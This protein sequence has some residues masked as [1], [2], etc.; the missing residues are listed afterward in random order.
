MKGGKPIPSGTVLTLVQYKAVLDDKG[1]PVEGRPA[2]RFRK[3]DLVAYTVMEKRTGWGAEYGPELR[4]GDWEYQVFGAGQV[5]V[6]I[7]QVAQPERSLLP[8]PQAARRAGLRDLPGARL[9]GSAARHR[10]GRATRPATAWRSRA[11]FLFG[12]E[13]PTSVKNQPVRD[14][15][16]HRRL[17]S[18]GDDRRRG[19]HAHGPSSSKVSQSQADYRSPHRAGHPT[20]H[21]CGLHPGMKGKVDVQPGRAPALTGSGGPRPPF[22]LPRAM[23]DSRRWKSPR[24]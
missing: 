11:D 3:G 16:Q 23:L 20:T 18:P 8:V 24:S 5:R 2:G 10:G 13:K 21:I 12:P 4:N 9:S 17:A 7:E 1:A 15:D 6:P 19:R 22:S 14:L